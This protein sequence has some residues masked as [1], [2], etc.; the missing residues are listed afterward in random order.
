MK[1]LEKQNRN[2]QFFKFCLVGC[3]NVLVTYGIYYILIW[4]GINYIIANTI[5]YI[6]GIFN[7]Y[8]WNKKYVF[9]EK[10]IS[11]IKTLV[12][13]FASYG[14]T[15]CISTTILYICTALIGI[16]ELISPIVTLFI[17]TPINFMLNKLWVFKKDKSNEEDHN[18]GSY[19]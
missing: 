13:T 14:I 12:K 7:A 2:I 1:Y 5:G 6:A 16:S 19:I 8:I 3:S 11:T 15:Y 18:T 4:C 10:K 9:N 17:T